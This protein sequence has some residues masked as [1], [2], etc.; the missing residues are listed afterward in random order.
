MKRGFTLLEMMV[1]IGILGILIGIFAGGFMGAPKKAQKQKCEVLVKNVATAMTRLFDEKGMW[2]KALVDNHNKEAG[3][4]AKAAYP[5]AKG[6]YMSLSC[7]AAEQKC[8]GAD[9]FG[10][11]SPWAQ[12]VVKDRGDKA[13]ES[14]AVPGGGTIA[15]HRL[16]YALDLDG[17][18]AID[19]GATLGGAAVPVRATVAVWCCGQD[20]K[21]ESYAVGQR[22]DDVYSWTYGD[23]QGVQ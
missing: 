3:L 2:P 6:N 9:R 1:V 23:T 4:D 19:G 21:I 17:D 8:T 10:V 22:K 20:G 13:S 7:D 12:A 16:R 15:D 18:G 14:D 11:I 5:L